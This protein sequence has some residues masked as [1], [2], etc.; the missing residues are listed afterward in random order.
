ME[1]KLPPYPKETVRELVKSRHISGFVQLRHFW[2]YLRVA[3]R[4][5]EDKKAQPSN[6]ASARRV[7]SLL[8]A[9][10][11]PAV[12]LRTLVNDLDPAS[13][14]PD[15]RAA[16]RMFWSAEAEVRW[17][18]ENTTERESPY[19]HYIWR[20]ETS[21]GEEA[22]FWL[23]GLK[24]LKSLDILAAYV[25]AAL[26]RTTGSPPG[27]HRNDA[28]DIWVVN[29]ENYWTQMLGKRFTLQVHR[30]QGVSQAFLFCRQA[31]QGTD[32]SVTN[33]ALITA[34]RKLIKTRARQRKTRKNP[35]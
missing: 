24:V 6:R 4:I 16:T 30:G 23:D 12:S 29:M 32:P 18:A 5:Y 10:L 14:D 19:G 21:P 35:A 3:K 2:R 27:R 28:L 22:I 26:K 11:K 9:I 34:M 25:Q 20:I 15:I 13:S 33:Q 1:L 17:L 8:Q 7:R 31:L